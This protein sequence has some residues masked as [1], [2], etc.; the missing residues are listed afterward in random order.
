MIV[1]KTEIRKATTKDLLYAAGCLKFGIVYYLQDPV[2]RTISGPYCLDKYHNSKILENYY[3]SGLI[4]VPVID[5][6]FDVAN[7]LQQL[8]YKKNCEIKG[9]NKI[10]PAEYFKA[11]DS[12]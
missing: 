4:Y 8:D 7:N 3:N 1:I 9:I 11:F 2:K 10:T 12:K 5:F 6:S